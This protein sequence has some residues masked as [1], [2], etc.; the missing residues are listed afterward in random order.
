MR[1]ISHYGRRWFALKAPPVLVGKLAQ[2]R[3]GEELGHKVGRDQER[4]RRRRHAELALG[5]QRQNRQDQCRARDLHKDDT[6]NRDQATIDLF[7]A[8]MS[9]VSPQFSSQ[10]GGH[11]GTAAIRQGIVNTNPGTVKRRQYCGTGVGEWR[12]SDWGC[13]LHLHP[14]CRPPSAAAP[15]G[16]RG[17]VCVRRKCR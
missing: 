16:K 6:Q 12:W 13:R 10:C 9:D 11:R 14:W 17:Q 1:R 7:K 15:Q 4:D 2:V 5:E 3:P 8:H